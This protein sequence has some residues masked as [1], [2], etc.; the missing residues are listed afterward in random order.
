LHTET[1]TGAVS[2]PNP[3]ITSS[4]ARCSITISRPVGVAG[5]IVD[6]GAAT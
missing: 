2:G 3:R 1:P 6:D 4:R 5:S